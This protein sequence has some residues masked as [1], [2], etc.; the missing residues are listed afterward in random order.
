MSLR[1][2]NHTCYEPPVNSYV[3]SRPAGKAKRCWVCGRS[4]SNYSNSEKIRCEK[5][6]KSTDATT[7]HR[8]C[9]DQL[10]QYV[11]KNEHLVAPKEGYNCHFFLRCNELA[12][13]YMKEIIY[14][15]SL[16]KVTEVTK[17]LANNGQIQ[18]H[19]PKPNAAGGTD[20][21][22]NIDS[23]SDLGEDLEEYNLNK[24]QF[25]QSPQQQLLLV[26]DQLNN[27]RRQM[28]ELQQLYINKCHE[29]SSYFTQ[30]QKLQDLI[31]N[32]SLARFNLQNKAAITIQKTFRGYQNRSKYQKM[33]E[34][35]IVIQK[36]V[37]MIVARRSYKTKL[38]SVKAKKKLAEKLQKEAEEKAVKDRLEA[39]NKKIQERDKKEK[40]RKEREQKKLENEARKKKLA[41]EMKQKEADR[42]KR[43]IQILNEERE[44]KRKLDEEKRIKDKQRAHEREK[45]EQDR[46]KRNKEHFERSASTPDRSRTSSF[47]QSW[48]TQNNNKKRKFERDGNSSGSSTP[49]TRN[50]SDN[51][52]NFNHQNSKSNNNR[53][54]KS[55]TK[56]MNSSSAEMYASLQKNLYNKDSNSQS[57]SSHSTVQPNNQMIVNNTMASPVYS[58]HSGNSYPLASPNYSNFT[59]AYTSTYGN[60]NAPPWGMPPP[61]TTGMRQPPGQPYQA[62]SS[63]SYSSYQPQVA[64]FGPPQANYAIPNFNNSNFVGNTNPWQKMRSDS[65]E[66]SSTTEDGELKQ[67]TP[68]SWRS[69]ER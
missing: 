10:L 36:N 58:N 20:T 21:Q 63:S 69:F 44:R 62:N 40:L 53:N 54:N 56:N 59:P 32:D 5:A 26:K 15:G 41:E 57:N 51:M 55:A 22:L 12:H 11:P 61:N 47:T 33:R 29:E 38:A 13:K 14:P 30:Y 68:S 49:S 48:N 2:Q 7:L 3:K 50:Y 34:A 60:S 23:D 39:E 28:Y 16:D 45:A 8:A 4:T 52:P 66:L 67:S 9:Y 31:C 25:F 18:I 27:V 1:R 35:A 19:Q 43:R 65:S 64:N 42:N 37:K 46:K 24:I 6:L 17:I